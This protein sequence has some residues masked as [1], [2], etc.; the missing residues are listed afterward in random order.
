V[1]GGTPAAGR[2]YFSARVAEAAAYRVVVESFDWL[3]CGDG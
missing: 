1:P 2:A 3:R